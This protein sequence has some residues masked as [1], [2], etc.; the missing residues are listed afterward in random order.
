MTYE[1]QRQQIK[2]TALNAI[3]KIYHPLYKFPYREVYGRDYESESYAEQREGRIRG[4]IEQM[5]K[6]LDKLKVKNNEH[7]HQ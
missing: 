4:I 3:A 5:N 7:S 6:A 2:N 1:E